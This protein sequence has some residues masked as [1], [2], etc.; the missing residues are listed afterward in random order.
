MLKEAENF[1]KLQRT[2]VNLEAIEKSYQADADLIKK[3]IQPKKMLDIGCGIAG[4]QVFFPNTEH[5]L[6]DKSQI[7]EDLHYG[8]YDKGSFYNSLEIAKN[9]LINEGI[10]KEMIHLHEADNKIPFDEKFDLIISLISCGFHY[11]LETYLTQIHEKLAEG[12]IF[13]ADIRRGYQKLENA[14]I[15]REFEIIKEF[16]KY[17]RYLF[18]K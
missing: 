16:R 14:D 9:N 7:D 13:I 2:D 10:K 18:R 15:F 1:A 8:Y 5:F 17:D 12:G 4:V 3:F 11:P 6:I